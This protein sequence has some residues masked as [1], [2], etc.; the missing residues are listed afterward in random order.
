VAPP[1]EEIEIMN[2]IDGYVLR[3]FLRVLLWALLAFVLIFILVDL[4][5][6]LDNFIDD[7][8]SSFSIAKYYLF[9]LPQVIDLVLPV[10]ML[11]AS[12]F[13]LGMLSKNNEYTA[14]LSA[15]VD[16]ARMTRVLL[17][18]AFLVSVAAVVFREVVVA[19]ANRLQHEVLEHEIEGKPRDT[20]QG[21]SNFTH[22]GDGGR[23]FVIGR[24]RPRPPTLESLSI[25][26]FRDSTM[27]SRIDAQRAVWG[28]GVWTL[29][30]G[31]VRDFLDSTESVQSFDTRV[32]KEA[33]ET[34]ED[35]SRRT[36]DPDDMNWR[37]LRR[38][39]RWV[40]RTGGDST[41]YEAE[42]AHK[43][44]FPLVNFLVVVLGV[45]LGAARRRTTLWA[46]FGYTVGLA[47]GYYILMDFGL[48]LG[49]GGSVPVWVSA[50][51]GNILYGVAGLIFFLRARR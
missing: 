20:L 33:S 5:D 19:E 17:I 21:R 23:V 39:A 1:L 12:L 34:P 49:R 10:S 35:F 29:E 7:N 11:L 27:V 48:E 38:F 2:L 43:L 30:D 13:T 8:A 36:V 45:A 6:H 14:V 41:P 42:M 47:F 31:C 46:G 28:D 37:E 16:L 26:V 15:G 22:V 24:F 4:F 25:Q 44:S 18:L 9:Q 3:A 51:A 40:A 32:L 50:W